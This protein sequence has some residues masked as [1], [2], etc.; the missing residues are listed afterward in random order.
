MGI[1]SACERVTS[2][3]NDIA[4]D[5]SRGGE[6]LADALRMAAAAQFQMV[7]LEA[8]EQWRDMSYLLTLT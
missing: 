8:V 7:H 6:Q 2:V 4:D 1:S 5:L 3:D